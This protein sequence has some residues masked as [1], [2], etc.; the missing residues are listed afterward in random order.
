MKFTF[1]TLFPDLIETWSKTGLIGAA[2]KKHLLTIGIVN[3]REFAS[4]NHK[5]VD[6]TAFGGSDG[7]VMKFEPLAKSIESARASGGHVAFLTPQGR[8]W[9]QPQAI[10]WQ[11]EHDHVILVCGR[12]A[13]FDHRLIEAYADEEVSVGDYILNGGE[14]AGLVVAETVARLL[15]GVLGNEKSIQR[16]SFAG[17]L[18]EAPSFTRPREIQG[19]QVPSPLLSGHHAEI[20]RFERDLALVRTLQVRPE[21]VSSEKFRRELKESL[22][23]LEKLSDSEMKSLGLTM[24]KLHDLQRELQ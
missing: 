24:Q 11:K 15:P 9:V 2:T 22:Q 5:S 1:I 7:M 21:W 14:L 8:P 10:E 20:E 12:Y 17:G 23:R 18:L 16:E 19:M 3:P 4:D 6:D 13:G